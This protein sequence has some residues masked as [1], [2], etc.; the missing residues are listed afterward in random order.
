MKGLGEQ[1]D[2]RL[3][4]MY[5]SLSEEAKRNVFLCS[6]DELVT[7]D[8]IIAVRTKKHDVL[9]LICINKDDYYIVGDA[10][11][12]EFLFNYAEYLGGTTIN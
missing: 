2:S 3:T 6:G 4:E 8:S 9:Q 1:K 5:K 10:K 12:C 7:F 11:V